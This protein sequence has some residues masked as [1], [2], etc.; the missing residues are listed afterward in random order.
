MTRNVITDPTQARP[1][2]AVT[3]KRP[4]LAAKVEEIRVHGAPERKPVALAVAGF[5]S[6]I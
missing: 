5:N 1:A 3:R 4:S 2:V 6:S